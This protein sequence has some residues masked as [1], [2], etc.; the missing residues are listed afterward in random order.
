MRKYM[1]VEDIKNSGGDIISFVKNGDFT[2]GVCLN[3]LC[4]PGFYFMAPWFR[5]TDEKNMTVSAR[6]YVGRQRSNK[7]FSSVLSH[8]RAG[9]SQLARTMANNGVLYAV[10]F[11]PHN[12]MKPLTTGFGKGQISMA[13][14][15][16]HN[17]A[18]QNL[19][20]MNRIL[21]DNFKF[22]LQRY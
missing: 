2:G 1:T 5:D 4:K 11:I 22:V 3:E 21:N 10:Y 20:E 15:K 9:R 7:G 14:T 18:F 17:D 19:E 8:I 6:F 13:F 12:K 16:Q